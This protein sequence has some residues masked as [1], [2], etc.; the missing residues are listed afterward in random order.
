MHWASLVGLAGMEKTWGLL[1][2]FFWARR[3]LH[4]RFRARTLFPFVRSVRPLTVLFLTRSLWYVS[5]LR[6]TDLYITTDYFRYQQGCYFISL[7]PCMMHQKNWLTKIIE[8]WYLQRI[9]DS[10]KLGVNMTLNAGCLPSVNSLFQP[11]V[12][13]A[14]GSNSTFLH[15]ELMNKWTWYK[16]SV[17]R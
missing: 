10:Q 13:W 9:L 16:V 12:L 2:L 6:Q 5:A 1:M 8:V 14:Y 3:G 11:Y 7:F 15:V 4:K 17:D